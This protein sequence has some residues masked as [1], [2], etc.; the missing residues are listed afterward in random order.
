MLQ[1]SRL[2]A[3]EL[4]KN[5]VCSTVICD[6]MA[7]HF[8]KSKCIDKIFVGADRIAANGDVANKIGTYSLA[9]LAKYHKIPFYVVAPFSTF[10]MSLFSGKE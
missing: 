6:S 10:D 4:A 5:K 7:A 1:G 2:T 3:W 9:V 8:M